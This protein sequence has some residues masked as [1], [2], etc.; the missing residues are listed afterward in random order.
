M[1]FKPSVT[2][3]AVIE[4]QGKFLLVE[5][6]TP[7]GRRLN[8]PAGHLEQAESPVDACIREVREETARAF[9]PSAFLGVYLGRFKRPLN[10]NTGGISPT[11]ADINSAN[12]A[13]THEDIT[14]VRLAFCGSVGQE[15]AGLSYDKEIIRTLWMSA[16]DIRAAPEQHRSPMVML[17]I[18]D[19][20]AGRR[21][22]LDTVRTHEH[23]FQF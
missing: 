23:V 21:M 5:E 14:Y 18:N 16:D 4:H 10:N 9:A 12:P 13:N 20:L 11:L 2:V 8:Q 6:H 7:E 22:P 17:C 3:A 15:I 1:R 19:Y